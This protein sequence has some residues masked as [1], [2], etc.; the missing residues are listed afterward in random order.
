MEVAAKQGGGAEQVLELQIVRSLSKNAL[1]LP[2]LKEKALLHQD[3][4]AV[5]EGLDLAAA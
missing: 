4:R 2:T 5:P 1:L 3:K